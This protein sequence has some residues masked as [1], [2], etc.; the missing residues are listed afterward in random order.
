MRFGLNHIALN[1]LVDNFLKSLPSKPYDPML[2]EG[3]E[4]ED[5]YAVLT[6]RCP[7]NKLQALN[8]RVLFDRRTWQDIRDAAEE[9][10]K[11]RPTDDHIL[12]LGDD[13]ITD[14]GVSALAE[15]LASNSSLQQIE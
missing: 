10:V 13:Q 8:D 4:N 7:M 11:P 6:Q 12:D 14:A 1:T 2:F 5:I 9:F 15:A 3:V